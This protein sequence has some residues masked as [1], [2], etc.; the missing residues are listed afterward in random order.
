MKR[1]VP[2]GDYAVI[3]LETTGFSAQYHEIIELAAVRVEAGRVTGVFSELVRPRRYISRQ[4]TRLTGITAEMTAGARTLA[5]V[6]PDYLAF[7][8]GT[9][10]LG[11]NIAFD[12][13]FLRAGCSELQLAVPDATSYCTM[14]LARRL[15]PEWTH[16]R[17]DDLI[18][19]YDIPRNRAH[20]A[21]DDCLATHQAFTCLLAESRRQNGGTPE[22]MAA[23]EEVGS[24]P[25]YGSW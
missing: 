8:A 12:L 24:H 13:E 4:I 9:D 6:L 22:E 10:L 25:R 17:L 1:L 14:R 18:R 23:R 15:H 2:P 20:R 3:D 21:L 7:L 16:H 5:K 11:H 19:H